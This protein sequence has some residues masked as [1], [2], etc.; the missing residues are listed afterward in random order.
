LEA[1]GD[2]PVVFLHGARQTGKST[3]A[4]WLAQGA[5]P[6]RY[7]TLDD[8]TALSAASNDPAGFLSGM[9]GPVILDEVQRSPGLFPAIKAEVDRARRPG[10]FLLTGSADVLLLPSISESLVGRMEILTLWPFSAG[11]RNGVKEQFIDV[12]FDAAP[13]PVRRRSCSRADIFARVQLGGFPEA[14]AR[15]AAHR[16]GA[17][18]GSYITTVLQRDVRDLANIEHLTAVPRLLSSLATR[19][20]SLLNY[21]ELSRTLALSQST[22]KRYMALL[23]TTFLIQ[24]L[25][26][27]S[28]N[29][30]K[31][32]VKSPKLLLTDTGLMS[33]LL[34]LGK[35]LQSTEHAVIGPLLENFVVMELRK[36]ATW[37][38]TPVQLFHFRTQGPHEVD[39]VL[40]NAAGRIVGVEVKAAATVSAADFRHLRYLKEAAGSRF[41]RGVVLYTGEETISFSPSMA[42]M[43]TT[44]VWD[45][46]A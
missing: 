22:L 35:D 39:V 34:G 2:T 16:R 32:L 42:A 29:I 8:A 1:L 17:W 24:L 7:T 30:G 4:Q 19:S 36:Q 45:S 26:P 21:S 28:A 12:L 14:V 6:A 15:R 40:E 38:N 43:P 46:S 41:V 44:A 5:Y 3:L 9:E 20:V 13:L 18:F 23:E 27:W 31:R 33:H 11:E 25:P 37:C 10:R